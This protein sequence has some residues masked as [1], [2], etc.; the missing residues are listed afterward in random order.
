MKALTHPGLVRRVRVVAPHPDDETIGAF[1]LMRHLSRHGVCVEVTIV[2]DGAASHPASRAWLPER[3]RLARR[4]ETLAAVRL[5]GV[6]A[7][8]VRFLDYPDGSLSALGEAPFRSLV[9]RLAAGP[10]PDLVLRPSLSDTH[11]D[12]ETVAEACR[13]AWPPGIPQATYQVW[14]AHSQPPG[15]QPF[16]LGRDQLVK[17]AALRLYKSQ[18]GLITDDPDGFSMNRDLQRIF[19][20]PIEW[21]GCGP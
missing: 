4:R 16:V 9:Q 21:Y 6:H 15:A 14:P 8:S 13:Q 11:P 12:H 19:A 1:G 3:L 10:H 2:T 18:T 5:A 17:Q 20:G 7:G